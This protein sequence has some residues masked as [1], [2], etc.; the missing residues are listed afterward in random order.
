MSRAL[1]KVSVRCLY[2]DVFVSKDDL[3][4]CIQGFDA[5]RMPQ[6]RIL[7]KRPPLTVKCR[8]Q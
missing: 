2:K 7:I 5:L 1:A 4:H 8:P 3:Q 6:W